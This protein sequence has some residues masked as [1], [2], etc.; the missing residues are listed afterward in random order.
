MKRKLPVFLESVALSLLAAWS[1]VGCLRSAF[2]LPMAARQPVLLVWLLW[3]VLCS[4]V[5]FRR[6]GGALLLAL[7]AVG[8]AWLWYGGVFGPQ[9]VSLLGTLAKAYDGGYGFGVPQALQ[10][11]Q[12]AQDLPLAVLGMA[13]GLVE[14]GVA[15]PDAI[16][17]YEHS[18]AGNDAAAL[19]AAELGFELASR[20]KYGDTTV[21]VLRAGERAA[22]DND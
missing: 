14:R 6:W 4:T 18:L 12:T 13:A 22:S 9:T 21:D 7:A 11:P 15:A 20:K 5:L 2:Q 16:V 3:A 17:V 19:A 1:A 10:V 8:A